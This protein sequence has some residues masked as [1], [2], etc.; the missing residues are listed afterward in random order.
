MRMLNGFLA[1]TASLLLGSAVAAQQAAPKPAPAQR[2]AAAA[3]V[4]TVAS[5][6]QIME[7]MVGPS[8]TLV[9]NAAADAPKDDK[10]WTAIQNAA[11]TLTESGN[12]LMLGDRVKDRADWMKMSGAMIDAGALALKAAIDKNAD[13]LSM[14]GDEVYNTCDTCHA[15]YLTKK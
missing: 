9:F 6:K 13:A 5:M 10:G 4:R 1:V 7:A 14:A 8:S 11:V 12:L 2:P 15:K 3:G